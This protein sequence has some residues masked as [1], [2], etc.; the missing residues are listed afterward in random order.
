MNAPEILVEEVSPNGNVFAIVEQNEHCCHFYLNGHESTSFGIKSCWVRNF[1]SAPA[2]LA[3]DAMRT[4]EPPMLTRAFCL[5]PEGVSRFRKG[6][7]KII[8]AEEGDAAA[9]AHNGE[10]I[11]VIP[12]W[13]GTKGF[14]GYAK[15]CL[16]ESPLC[17]E[18]GTPETNVQFARYQRASTFW[19]SW[20]DNRNPWPQLRDE[21]CGC[22]EKN[23]GRHSNYYAIDGGN[24]PPK[25]ILRIPLRESVALATIGVC[26]R[27]QPKVEL[28]YEDPS[29]HRRIELGVGLDASLPDEAVKKMASYISGQTQL[30]W[31]NF[32]FLGKGHTIPSDVAAELSG[33]QLPFVL[34]VNHA[35]GSLD[36]ALP[37]FR[38]DPINL[39][40]MIPISE[41]ERKFAET[42]GSTELVSRLERAGV[43][44]I[45]SMQRSSV[46]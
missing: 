46:C 25:A 5:H 3:V 39:L 1:Q 37:H 35:L 28:H 33:G 26:I 38:G 6:E 43:N 10:I 14:Y 23:L 7:L 30:P 8:W 31:S 13:S 41:T 4:G 27:P 24:W 16:G 29:S 42:N 17:W 12:S 21:L 2:Q 15:D 40:W 44:W 32:T 11:A 22:L 19:E 36:V 9:L 34:L 20:S 45:A 18:L